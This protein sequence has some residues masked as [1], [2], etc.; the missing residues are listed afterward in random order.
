MG[1][2]AYYARVS[3]TKQSNDR[4]LEMIRDHLGE[5]AFRAAR[6]YVDV[7]SG[8]SDDREDFRALV[9]DIEAGLVEEVVTVEVSRVSRRLSTAANFIDLCVKHEVAL[10]TLGDSFPDLKGDGDVFDKLMGQLTAWM[11]EYE[12]EMIRER[13][14]SGVN[15][16]IERGKWVGRPPYGFQTDEK[17]Y[18]QVKPDDYTAMQAA[19]EMAQDPTN[20]ESVNAIARACNV[21]QSTLARTL[22]DDE[23]LAL[24]VDGEA[25]DHRLA[26]A[27]DD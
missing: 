12:R 8:A 23:K 2:I 19:I 6:A 10:T 25:E 24:Y 17:G 16:A 1:R 27:L 18:L 15:R 9:D 22:K 5:E 4:Q 26:T 14:Q 3:T 11:M 7:G 13:V 21:P 20:D